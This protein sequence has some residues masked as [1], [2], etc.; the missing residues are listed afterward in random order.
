[1]IQ[2]LSKRVYSFLF[3]VFLTHI[4]PKG[5]T[6]DL[7]CYIFYLFYTRVY[8]SVLATSFVHFV[9]GSNGSKWTKD[10][11]TLIPLRRKSWATTDTECAGKRVRQICIIHTSAVPLL[12][13]SS[14]AFA[15]KFYLDYHPAAFD[16]IEEI[17][18]N[19]TRDQH[20]ARCTH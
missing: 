12:A 20:M 17:M 4:I 19:R 8:C 5:Y 10:P 16:C 7:Q 18:F 3:K 14:A 6:F 2:P 9:S 1:M 13:N 11:H 15:N